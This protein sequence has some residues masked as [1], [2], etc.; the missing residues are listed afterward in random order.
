MVPSHRIDQTL[1]L[2]ALA[3]III[4][5]HGRKEAPKCFWLYGC[6]RTPGFAASR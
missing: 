2:A 4:G 3:L 1:A 5:G 6:L